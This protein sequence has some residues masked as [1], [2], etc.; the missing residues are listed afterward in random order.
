MKGFLRIF[1]FMGL[2][3]TDIIAFTIFLNLNTDIATFLSSNP[4]LLVAISELVFIF[5]ALPLYL[6]ITK[7]NL[8]DVLPLK[9]IGWKNVA[10]IAL[11]SFL[12]E[13]ITSLLSAL[14]SIFYPNAAMEIAAMFTLDNL[15]AALIALAVLPSLVEEICFRGAILNASKGMSVMHAVII[16][17]VL[18]GLIHM[19]LQQIPYALFLGV[20]FSLY[21]IYTKSIYSSILA[22]FLVNAPNVLLALTL[23]ADL[24]PA[25]SVDELLPSLG[26]LAISAVLF[27]I[28]F[29]SVFKRFRLYNLYRNPIQ[30]PN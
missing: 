4:F 3:L 29:L 28:C 16:N 25:L 2:M 1:L 15:P 20:I 6:L 5:P 22:H 7:Q 26:V 30:G 21:V 14:T 19:N 18:F 10:Y 12:L 17:G 9:P 8:K 23:S 13:P 24:E 11:M 27:F